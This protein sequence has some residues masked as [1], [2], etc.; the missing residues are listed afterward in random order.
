MKSAPVILE[1][2]FIGVAPFTGAW[3]EI[4][5]RHQ[6]KICGKVAPFTGAWIEIGNRKSGG[7]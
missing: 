7:C 5:T 6:Q 3:I 2:I 1:I 4:G